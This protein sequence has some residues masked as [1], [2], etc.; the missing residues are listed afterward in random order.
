[1]LD[2]ITKCVEIGASESNPAAAFALFKNVKVS[3][4]Y[5]DVESVAKN[6]KAFCYVCDRQ[7]KPAPVQPDVLIAGYPCNMN[8]V[9]NPA[10]FVD[11]QCNNCHSRV[12]E[13]VVQLAKRTKPVSVVL[14]NVQ[15]ITK[16]RGKAAAGDGP[17][18]AI[19]WVHQ[20]LAKELS[21]YVWQ[22]FPV[23]NYRLPLNLK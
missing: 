18:T 13:H 2:K 3:H 11:D 9:L 19:E 21:D 4:I 6:H 15:G 8:S 7:C 17:S 10:R 1:M 16:R 5:S 12:F 22:D 14:E 23:D 20:V